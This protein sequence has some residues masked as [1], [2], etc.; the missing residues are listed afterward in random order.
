MSAL[1]LKMTKDVKMIPEL[2]AGGF[3]SLSPMQRVAKC[4][5]MAAE[6]ERLAVGKT[7]EVRASYLDLAVRWVDLANEME[8][9]TRE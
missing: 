1:T 9:A 3:L 5:E 4:R 7:G 8:S 6:A 2:D